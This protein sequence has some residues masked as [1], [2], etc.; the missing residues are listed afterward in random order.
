MS[1]ERAERKRIQKNTAERRHYI[2]K[3]LLDEYIR[4]NQL[5]SAEVPF[6]VTLDMEYVNPYD[7]YHHERLTY[8]VTDPIKKNFNPTTIKA[9]LLSK[10]EIS[11]EEPA[12]WDHIPKVRKYD[13]ELEAKIAEFDAV[14][15]EADADFYAALHGEDDEK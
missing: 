10:I 5:R 8:R 11:S 14:I 7:G 6:E 9:Q 1:D 2:R 13:A 12:N 4:K 3:S 15:A